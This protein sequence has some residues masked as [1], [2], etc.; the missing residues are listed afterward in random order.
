MDF[1]SMTDQA[2]AA[3]LGQ[4]IRSLRLRK[5][6]TQQQ[7]ATATALSLNVIK[8]MESGRGKLSTLIAVLRELG[9]LQEL[10]NGI[11]EPVVS[12]LQ[13]A[14]M[15]GKQRRRASGGRSRR[16]PQDDVEW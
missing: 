5:N 7:L 16:T 9:G 13:L 10:V 4:R 8:S 6:V 12:P 3:E 1:H 2:I 15:Q 14:R 11:P